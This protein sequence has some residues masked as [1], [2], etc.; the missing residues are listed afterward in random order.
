M[1][2]KIQNQYVS[3][4][5]IVVPEILHVDSAPSL[6]PLA[7]SLAFSKDHP[8]EVFFGDGSAWHTIAQSNG[9]TSVAYGALV[10]L[11]GAGGNPNLTNCQLA[12]QKNTNLTGTQIP[13]YTFTLNINQDITT[14]A[15]GDWTSAP[16]D[17][18]NQWL[19]SADNY[20]PCAISNGVAGPI[21]SY[22]YIDRA[23][24][25]IVVHFGGTPGVN[26]FFSYLSCS[27]Y[28]ADA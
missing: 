23:T 9:F 21:F 27:Y 10:N 6:P 1:S 5:Q 14:V 3:I 26:T 18:P 7:G 16:G 24:G 8:S 25:S 12:I 17:V 22:F 4:D 2:S 28:K 11:V 20:F 13:M 15:T 19:P